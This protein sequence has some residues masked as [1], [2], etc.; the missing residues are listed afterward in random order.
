M[1]RGLNAQPLD[2]EADTLTFRTMLPS[3]ASISFPSLLS[4]SHL[5]MTKYYCYLYYLNSFY[6]FFIRLKVHFAHLNVSLKCQAQNEKIVT[7]LYKIEKKIPNKTVIYS[8]TR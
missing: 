4:H 7:V 6:I 8:H 3:C 5:V 1:T 2:L